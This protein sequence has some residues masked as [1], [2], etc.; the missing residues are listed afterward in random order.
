MEKH[1]FLATATHSGQIAKA[2]RNLLIAMGVLVLA[3]IVSS[4]F[5]ETH[6]DVY[7]YV[8]TNELTRR[9]WPASVLQYSVFF[10]CAFAFFLFYIR[11]KQDLSK[12]AL[13]LAHDG[14]F[15]NQ[16]TLKNAFVP[17]HEI[18]K[19]ELRGHV[20][21]PV[22]RVFFKDAD[23]LLKKQPFLFRSISKTS[24]KDD[25]SLGIS[26]QECTGDLVGF[27][28]FIKSKGVPTEEKMAGRKPL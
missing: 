4:F 26:S 10:F 2:T 20:S 19:A 6:T 21:D 17:W 28:D 14:M 27:F 7:R 12:P 18:E 8:K 15:I 3:M 24:L 25:A 5:Y 11:K 22:L 23:A 1:V 13:G 9:G 16:Q